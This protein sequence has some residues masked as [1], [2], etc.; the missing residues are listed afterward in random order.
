MRVKKKI[1]ISYMYIEMTFFGSFFDEVIYIKQLH[2]WKVKLN[3][4][5]GLSKALYGL[6]QVFDV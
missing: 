2:Q 3:K 1:S 6:K 5:C 4:V